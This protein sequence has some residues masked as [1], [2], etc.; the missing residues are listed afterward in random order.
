MSKELLGM[1]A[2]QLVMLA[3]DNRITIESQAKE[4]DDLYKL[5]LEIALLQRVANEDQAEIDGLRAAL[6]E[7]VSALENETDLSI[8]CKVVLTRCKELIK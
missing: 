2:A 3:Q 7:V 5:K 4:I 1:S 6:V 8:K